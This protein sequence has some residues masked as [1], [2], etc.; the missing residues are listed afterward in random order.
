MKSYTQMHI[1]KKL[2]LILLGTLCATIAAAQQTGRYRITFTDKEN[3]IYSLERPQEFL[4]EKALA[5]RTQFEIE[6]SDEDLPVNAH[7]I[8][9]IVDCGAQLCNSSK[10]F[11]SAIFLCDSLTNFEKVKSFSFVK[12]CEFVATP[13]ALKENTTILQQDTAVFAQTFA[14]TDSLY[15]KSLRQIELMNGLEI[16]HAGFRGQGKTIAVIDAGFLHVDSSWAFRQA[17]EEGRILAVRDFT[18]S[19]SN[20]FEIGNHGLMTFST[21]AGQVPGKLIGTAPSANYVLLRSE[22]EVTEFPVEEDNWISAAEFADSLGV[23]IIST[24]LGYTTFDDSTMNYS[25]EQLY[26]NE[27]RIT[28]GAT[29]AAQKGMLIVNSAGNSGNSE[30]RYIS[31]PA[32]SELSLSVGA[33]YSNGTITAFSSRGIAEAPFLKPDIVA[34][35]AYV[36]AVSANGLVESRAHGTSFAC[37]IIAGISACLWQEFP[38]LTAQELKEIICFSSNH[39]DERSTAYGYGIPDIELARGIIRYY[40]LTEFFKNNHI[41]PVPASTQILQNPNSEAFIQFLNTDGL[42]IFSTSITFSAVDKDFNLSGIEKLPAGNYIV[43]TKIGTEYVIQKIVVT[44][45]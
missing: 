37:P 40:I 7:Y 38:Q 19:N 45:L 1:H 29:I 44:A 22:E 26:K 35:G 15:G 32:D 17:W 13:Y 25:I 4:S 3:S 27:I 39:S 9:S 23:D 31:A 43:K 34:M 6:I 41:Y 20:V 2:L 16:H 11:N 14:H 5:R 12:L 21:I 42:V 36:T 33:T 18:G 30:W 8:D 24:S 10:W 28:Q